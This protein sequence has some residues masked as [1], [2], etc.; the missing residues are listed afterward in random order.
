MLLSMAIPAMATET[1]PPA[2]GGAI[3]VSV[4]VRSTLSISASGE[5]VAAYPVN[6]SF[7]AATG[8]A[9]YSVIDG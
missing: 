2:D 8:I 9:S 1:D 6:Y 4:E 5:A 3:T 7:D